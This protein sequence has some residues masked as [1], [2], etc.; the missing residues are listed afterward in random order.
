MEGQ[1]KIGKQTAVNLL[2]TARDRLHAQW[3][4]L[5]QAADAPHDAARSF[6]I[7]TSLNFMP[8]PALDVILAGLLLAK[9]KRLNRSALLLAFAVWN[10]FVVLPLYASGY[11][12][13]GAIV[14]ATVP[15]A[16][17]APAPEAHL[18]YATALLVLNF[19]V[20]NLIVATLAV[21]SGYV[22]VFTLLK[23]YGG[24]GRFNL[25]LPRLLPQNISRTVSQ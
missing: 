4:E 19:L 2:T 24:R 9:Y 22:T 21:S 25:T 6:A 14:S 13:G 23:L 20:G 3:Q 18:V 8:L 16:A 17:L 11:K 5:L 1:K 10:N 15:T 12:L 7:G